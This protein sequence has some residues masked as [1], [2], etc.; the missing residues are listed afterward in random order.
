MKYL[1]LIW[2][3]LFRRK[4]RTILPLVSIVAAFLLF[5][6]LD[7]DRV[8]QRKVAPATQTY[9]DLRLLPAAVQ[10]GETVVVSPPAEL[11]DGSDVQIKKP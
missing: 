9:G 11:H 5:G 8:R 3:A 10:P 7:G 2:A 4:T 1:H 6:M